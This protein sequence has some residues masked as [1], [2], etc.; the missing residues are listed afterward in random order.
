[1]LQG[2]KMVKKQAAAETTHFILCVYY[3]KKLA[4][5]KASTT[6]KV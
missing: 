5:N 1:M 3:F 2:Q 4:T 6:Q